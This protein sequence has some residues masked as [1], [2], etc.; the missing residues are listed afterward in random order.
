MYEDGTEKR[1]E[2]LKE[3]LGEMGE[4]G[5]VQGPIAFHY[6]KHTKIGKRFFGNFNLTIQDDATV[7]IGDACVFA[8]GIGFQCPVHR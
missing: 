7:T 3:I 8:D 1:A 4:G 2:I 5:F 6:G